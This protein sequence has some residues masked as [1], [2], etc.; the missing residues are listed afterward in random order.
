MI[1]VDTSIWYASYVPEDPDHQ[2]AR[3]LLLSSGSKLITT[4]YVVDE[5][6]TLLVARRYRD[7]AVRNGDDFWN[8]TVC[9]LLWVGRQDASEGWR[10][11]TAFGDKTWSFT[12]CVSYAVMQ[13]LGIREAFALDDHFKQFGFL[14][15]S[16]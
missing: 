11:F 4:D 2:Q 13:R 1:F 15:V 5:L 10:V 12:D 3:E 8:E 16:P 6:L 7:I 9:D 14:V